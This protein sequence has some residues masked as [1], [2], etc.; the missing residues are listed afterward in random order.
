MT[1]IEYNNNQNNNSISINNNKWI[2]V[3][4][5][6]YC[7]PYQIRKKTAVKIATGELISLGILTQTKYRIE[8]Q[9]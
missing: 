8:S 5:Y 1:T 7:K 3:K 2:N 4:G 6:H 9:S